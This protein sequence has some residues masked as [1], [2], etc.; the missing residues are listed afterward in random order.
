MLDTYVL[1]KGYSI[2]RLD[3]FRKWESPTED[4]VHT[5]TVPVT[6]LDLDEAE[7]DSSCDKIDQG[8]ERCIKEIVAIVDNSPKRVSNAVNLSVEVLRRNFMYHIYVTA[9]FYKAQ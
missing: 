8:L 6:S 2:F 5:F 4:P 9:R 7:H 3:D 1:Q